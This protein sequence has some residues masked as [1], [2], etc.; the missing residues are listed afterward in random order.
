MRFSIIYII[1]LVFLTISGIS[2]AGTIKVDNAWIRALPPGISATAA[3][4]DM[5]NVGE[6]PDKLLAIKTAMS[7]MANI[8]ETLK[9]DGVATMVEKS[10]VPLPVKGKVSLSP[11]GMHVMLHGL[12]KD[13]VLGEKVVLNLVFEKAGAVPVEFTIKH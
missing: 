3:Y 9:K 6:K 7:S 13:L 5:E 10:S 12:Q 8:H 2:Q 4:F 11:G 1:G